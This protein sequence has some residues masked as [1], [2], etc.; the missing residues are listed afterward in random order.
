VDRIPIHPRVREVA[1]HERVPAWTFSLASGGD[2]QF[3]VTA[4]HVRV[5]KLKE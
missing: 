1:I 2:F 3:I 5:P 4:L